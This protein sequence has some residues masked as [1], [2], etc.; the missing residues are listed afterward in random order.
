MEINGK[1][2]GTTEL[3]KGDPPMGIVHGVFYPACGI[4][5]TLGQPN[6][7]L[8]GI[9]SW[10]VEGIQIFTNNGVRLVGRTPYLEQFDFE[11]DGRI[12]QISIVLKNRAE[13]ELHF[14]DHIKAFDN[15][16]N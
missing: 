14:S 6:I 3:E 11:Q 9:R 7:T 10:Q 16:F 8:D 4:E 15:S 1:L 13:Y 12:Y 2:I 5:N